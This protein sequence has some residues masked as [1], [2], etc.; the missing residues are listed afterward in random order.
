MV[1]GIM[2]TEGE[3]VKAGDELAR[4]DTSMI[5]QGIARAEAELGIAKAELQRVQV[6]ASPLE[7]AEAQSQLAAAGSAPVN[8]SLE[9]TAVAAEVA[10]SQAR[11]DYL[12]SLPL[13]EDVELSQ[14]KVASAQAVLDSEIA[15]LLS[16][17]IL[18]APIDG[19][20]TEVA[21]R[22]NQYVSTGETVIQLAD[23]KDLSVVVFVDEMDITGLSIGDKGKVTFDSLPEIYT[24]AAITSISPNVD[25]TDPND[26]KVVLKLLSIPDGVRPGL[27][28][29]VIFNP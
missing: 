2:V 9:A 5:A 8:T 21:A 28:A 14:A 26:F 19:I 17:G 4:L 3:S 22:P 20:V 1:S 25:L 18:R 13:P 11:L 29:E 12:E 6:G 16:S 24:N 27:T 7:I 10:A 15:A 23:L